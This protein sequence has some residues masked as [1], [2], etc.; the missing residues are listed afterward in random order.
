MIDPSAVRRQENLALI[1]QEVLT[2]IVRLR[3]DR[4][5]VSDPAAFR[6]HTREAL[7]TAT[8]Q[9]MSA[10]YDAADVKSAA[11]ATVAF[12]D[13]AI[14][15]SKN[16]IFADWLKKPLQEELFGTHVAGDVFF[17]KLEE[18]LGRVDSPDL[19]DLLEVYHLCLLLGFAG[20]YTAS[21]GEVTQM[22]DRVK[23]KIRQTRGRFSPLANASI[24][25][26]KAISRG[27]PW[28]CRLAIT[29]AAAA[30]LAVVLFVSYKIIL[31]SPISGLGGK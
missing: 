9:A 24:P 28:V 14:L 12:L 30:I 19:G 13:E 11:F 21:P 17:Q 18:L 4:Q 15:N 20:R 23:E 3:G 16:P 2:A 29:S 26:E 7:K 6:H 22:K 10:G 31:Q 27:D 8:R 5:S 25:K 1:Y